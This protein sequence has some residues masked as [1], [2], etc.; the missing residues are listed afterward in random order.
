MNTHLLQFLVSR[1]ELVTKKTKATGFTLAELLV[2]ILMAGIII[3]S[4]LYLMVNLLQTDQKEAATNQTQGEM[5]AAMDYITSD[6][7]NAVYV[8]D[9]VTKLSDY[10]PGFPTTYKPILAFWKAESVAEQEQSLPPSPS[11]PPSPAPTPSPCSNFTGLQQAECISLGIRQNT[12]TLVVYLQS[13]GEGG[14]WKGK[15]RIR[16][17]QLRKYKNTTSPTENM[18]N[19]S[20]STGYIDPSQTNT[21]FQQWPRDI[22]S[23]TVPKPSLQDP[24]L[25]A[26][27]GS[28]SVLVDFVDDPTNQVTIPSCPSAEYIRTPISPASPALPNSTSFFACV[29]NEADSVGLN[30]DVFIFLRGNPIGK[31]GI[32][33]VADKQLPTL[34]SQVIARGV[35]DKTPPQ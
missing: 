29:R 1:L 19:L 31:T 30:Q 25:S 15:S 21:S 33:S 4:L 24:L 17:Y 10:L 18:S 12:Y 7:R 2:S 35:L 9:D 23:T 20:K 3:S 5:Q 28:A 27:S 26:S 22:T 16:R 14:E 32:F 6:L 8:Y 11:I 34:Q 13:K